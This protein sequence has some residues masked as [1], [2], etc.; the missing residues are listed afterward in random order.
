[1]SIKFNREF[2]LKDAHNIGEKVHSMVA[3]NNTEYALM[4][5]N[6]DIFKLKLEDGTITV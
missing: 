5:N 4:F 6:S 1:M 3:T 2:K